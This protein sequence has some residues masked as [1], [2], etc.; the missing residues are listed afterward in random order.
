MLQ[1]FEEQ[2]GKL[3]GEHP[4][5]VS[6]KSHWVVHDI[7]NNKIIQEIFELQE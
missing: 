5:R 7:L 1:V 6:A 2:Y 3:Y 4:F